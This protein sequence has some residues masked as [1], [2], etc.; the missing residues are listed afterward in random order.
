[1]EDRASI[2][3]Q[4]TALRRVLEAAEIE[5]Q[6]LRNAARRAEAAL[7][8]LRRTGAAPQ[9]PRMVA[10]T[11]ERD[12]LN[13]AITEVRQRIADRRERLAQLI[14][15]LH[16]AEELEAL[17]QLAGAETPYLLF[18][19]RIETRFLKSNGHPE[20]W[21]R[22]FPDDVAIDTHE[23]GLTDAEAAAGRA[24]WLELWPRR[25]EAGADETPW[26]RLAASHGPARAAWIVQT[27][28]PVNL[29]SGNAQPV[30]PDPPQRPDAW[31]RPPYSRVMPDRWVVIGYRGGSIV[32]TALGRPI[33]DPLVV[34]LDPDSASEAAGDT[35]FDRNASWLVDFDA[36]ET[37]GMALRMRLNGETAGA[38]FD[39]LVVLGVKTSVDA[40]DGARLVSDLFTG[41]R[42]TGGFGL[43]RQGTPT[44][45]TTEARAGD[46]TAETASADLL[47]SVRGAP[48]Y[49]VV[50]DQA[51]QSDGQRIAQ[52]LGLEPTALQRVTR[53]GGHEEQ[54]ARAMATALWPATWG[55]Y[56]EQMIGDP[57]TP[58]AVNQLRDHYIGFVRGRGPLPALRVDTMP[59]GLLPT[60]AFS[61]WQA[62][63]LE[64]QFVGFLNR[65]RPLWQA[66]VA[67]IPHA[68]TVEDPEQALVRMLGMEPSSSSFGVR[69][70]LGD[71]YVWNLLSFG[72]NPLLGNIRTEHL[73]RTRALLQRLGLGTLDLPLASSAYD[74]ARHSWN[75]PI[76]QG[77]PLSESEPLAV[78]YIALLHTAK[79]PFMRSELFG[80]QPKPNALLY[81]LLRHAALRTYVD[82]GL[83]IKERQGLMVRSLRRDQELVGLRSGDNTLTPWQH[84][85]VNVPDVTGLIT[86]EDFLVQ[87]VLPPRP[88]LRELR[89][90]KSALGHLEPLATAELARLLTETLDTASHRLDAWFTS[91]AARRLGT[92]RDQTAGGLHIGAYGWVEDLRPS[93]PP[94]PAPPDLLIDPP[95]P[96]FIDEDNEGFMI[97]PSI[98][99]AVAAAILRNAYLTHA[100][101]SDPERLSTDLSSTRVR[102][103]LSLLDGVRQGQPLGAL[104]GYRF[105]RGLHEDH[106]GEELDQYIY[107][108]REL[109]PL[110]AR[111]LN[112]STDAVTAVGAAN[113]VDGLRL[114]DKWHA[115]A[116]PWGR[117]VGNEGLRLPPLNS[118]DRNSIEQELKHLDDDLDALGD[119]TLSESIYQVVLGNP[120]RAGAA[121]DTMAGV[122]RPYEPEVIR[123]PRTGVSVS[124][125]AMVLFT[126]EVNPGPGWPAPTVRA[127]AEPVLNGWLGRTIGN[128]GRIRCRVKLTRPDHSEVDREVTLATLGL[129]P[130]DFIYL[131]GLEGPAGATELEQRILHHV[132]RDQPRATTAAISFARQADWPASALAFSEVLELARRLRE[133]VTSA[134]AAGP[135]DFVLP[136]EERPGAQVFETAEF[137]A[138]A[139]A[140]LD[141]SAA[142]LAALDAALAAF[143]E[144]GPSESTP[145]SLRPL[146]AALLEAAMFG[147]QGAI[148]QAPSGD[149]DDARRVIVSQARSVRRE[150]SKRVEQ[151]AASLRAFDDL[152]ASGGRDEANAPQLRDLLIQTMRHVFGQSFCPLPRFR[153]LNVEEVRLALN[154][155]G[156]L[157]DDADAPLRWFQQGARISAGIGRY[158]IAMLLAEGL[159]TETFTLR[160][161]QLPYQEDDR[162][163]GLPLAGSALPG[164]G[165]VSL[166][167]HAPAGFD[168]TALFAGLF[169]DQFEERIP[170]PQETIGVSFHFDQP[171][172]RAPQTLLLAV[173]PRPTATWVWDDLL[174]TVTE[175]LDMAKI[176]AVDLE[177]LQGFGHYLPA[178]VVAFNPEGATVSSD[179]L[180]HVARPV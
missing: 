96:V 42:F 68:A 92:M 93:T 122:G 72:R 2:R 98:N 136:E 83:K 111:K 114:L 128:P 48:Q 50:Q 146:R 175:T 82:T 145:P 78:N 40:E 91:L 161:G 3:G 25:A 150:L 81:V 77:G 167:V 164:Q 171:G 44:N 18:P 119:I 29:T 70:L 53:A 14:D 173:P 166:I 87:P 7:A 39:R 178:I 17:T 37:A 147:L 57:L 107:A 97:A 110:I 106:P 148:P 160:V 32:Q 139:R 135:A 102:R 179:L 165:R 66:A 71:E 170:N 26:Q 155:S 24:F 23:P 1:M 28:T 79:I 121:L 19:V 8:T 49:K 80:R 5:L 31:S 176:R 76:I 86:L 127:K 30:F 75:A 153:P 108:F 174:A 95:G 13:R 88:D 99:Q 162:W 16:Q 6:N 113:V 94:T 20:L 41:H 131:S 45:N 84:L 27:T 134:R 89:E 152:R 137:A 130:I 180:L 34:G 105:E 172:S 59:Y 4:I 116:I 47:R 33:P 10:A 177:A 22:V 67:R 69:Q 74:D 140:A 143:P 120:L 38:G 43:V 15:R 63:G 64:G 169:L 126:G 73:R 21:V 124:H 100:S 141:A 109:F 157:G 168:A 132:L 51:Q 123:T 149:S 61:R 158:E 138:R 36:A 65:L 12:R 55:Y 54:N 151:T 154:H 52:A 58:A 104:L 60:S 118:A 35:P 144:G 125:R 85:S 117:Q 112:D 46:S 103:A 101:P 90:F 133:V 159:G 56:L 156:L 11:R 115:G 129:A 9:D 62:D 163:M 142:A